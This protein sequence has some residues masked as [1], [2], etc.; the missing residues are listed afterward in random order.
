MKGKTIAIIIIL[1]ALCAKPSIAQT[2]EQILEFS[3]LM[4]PADTRIDYSMSVDP[5]NELYLILTGGFVFYKT[6]ISSQDAATCSFYPTCSVYA[7]NSIRTNGFLGI[8]D[9]IDRL[10]RCNG[11]SPENYLIHE[12]THRLYDPVRQISH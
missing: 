2:R 1:S 5:T 8:F 11:F 9:A 7:I 12:A 3:G 10:T 4:K 6:F